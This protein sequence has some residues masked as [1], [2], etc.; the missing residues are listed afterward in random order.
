MYSAQHN[1]IRVF[2]IEFLMKAQTGIFI[3]LIVHA[4]AVRHLTHQFSLRL[5]QKR[6]KDSM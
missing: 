1:Q 2:G 3:L 5:M 4:A 6:S